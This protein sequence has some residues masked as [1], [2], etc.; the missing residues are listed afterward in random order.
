MQ[1]A[2]TYV[3]RYS[4]SDE[5]AY[6]VWEG[7]KAFVTSHISQD[8]STTIFKMA[9]KRCLDF[10][11]DRQ[12]KKLLKLLAGGKRTYSRGTMRVTEESECDIENGSLIA[13]QHIAYHGKCAGFFEEHPLVYWMCPHLEC[14]VKELPTL[15]I[16]AMRGLPHDVKWSTPLHLDG[17][18]GTKKKWW[19][20]C[21]KIQK[22]QYCRTVYKAAYEHDADCNIEFTLDICKDLGPGP[23]GKEWEAHATQWR[24]PLTDPYSITSTKERI[25]VPKWTLQH[26]DFD[27]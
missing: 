16:K 23:E 15:F 14:Y 4:C 21:S 17:S 18:T 12:T 11:H 25:Y 2:K 5:E 24:F 13:V 19:G 9:M 7:F 3:G 6:C 1:N 27:I 20:S 8:F 10:G 22:C 26:S